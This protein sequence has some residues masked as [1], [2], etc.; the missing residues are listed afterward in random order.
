MICGTDDETTHVWF[1]QL[2]AGLISDSKCSRLF[3]RRTHT[4]SNMSNTK[5]MIS[6]KHLGTHPNIV[7]QSKTDCQRAILIR[8]NA[9][10]PQ[11][12]PLP[13]PIHYCPLYPFHL[14]GFLP[15]SLSVALSLLPLHTGYMWTRVLRGSVKRCLAG[16][17]LPH[18]LVRFNEAPAHLQML[19]SVASAPVWRFNFRGAARWWTRGLRC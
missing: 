9:R 16:S 12:E 19:A 11:G 6:T 8:S 5:P 18:V 14:L 7:H 4:H 17:C 3:R 15:P 13:N 1:L 10:S 2:S